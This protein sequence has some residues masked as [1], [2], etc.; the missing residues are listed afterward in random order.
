MPVPETQPATP[1]V[2]SVT[3][4]WELAKAVRPLTAKDGRRWTTVRLANPQDTSEYLSIWLEGDPT[5]VLTSVAPRTLITLRVD[6]LHPGKE[7]GEL[8]ATVT[9]AALEAAF[10]GAGGRTV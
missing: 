7:R 6:G 3:F 8:S 2:G 9:R 5:P 1:V 10:A 4:T